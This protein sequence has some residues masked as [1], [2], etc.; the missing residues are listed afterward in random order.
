MS[1]KENDD[2]SNNNYRLVTVIVKRI[3]K[4]DYGFDY[5]K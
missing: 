5:K 1:N 4:K 2:S 3:A